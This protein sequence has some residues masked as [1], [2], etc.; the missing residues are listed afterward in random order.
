MPIKG[1]FRDSFK[2]AKLGLC[3]PQKVL[4]SVNMG[5]NFKSIGFL[6]L[7]THFLMRQNDFDAFYTTFS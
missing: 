3:Y 5:A 6:L 7:M 4:N 2:F 1:I